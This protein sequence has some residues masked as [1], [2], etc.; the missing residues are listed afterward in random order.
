[1]AHYVHSILFAISGA[2][3]F[4][5]RLKDFRLECFSFL[6]SCMSKIIYI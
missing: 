6:L 4:R 2:K 5:V 1:M 3:E